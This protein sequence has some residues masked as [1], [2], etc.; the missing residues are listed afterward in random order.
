MTENVDNKST[1]QKLSVS[2]DETVRLLPDYSSMQDDEFFAILNNSLA[3]SNIDKLRRVVK[4]KIIE[5]NNEKDYIMVDSGLK[6]EGII[7]TKEFFRSQDKTQI[8]EGNEIETYISSLDHCGKVVVSREKAIREES[9][10]KIV[11]AHKSGE[12]VE[13]LV[14]AKTRSG[15]VVDID[16]VICFLPGSQ[17]DS[18]VFFEGNSILGTRQKVM[19]IHL[20]TKLRNVVVSRK[21]V[22]DLSRKEFRNAFLDKVQEGDIVEGVVKNITPYGAFVNLGDID[23]LLHVTDISWE[24][25]GHPAEVLK[26]GQKL[27]VKILKFSRAE[28][29]ISLGIKQL[30]DNPWNNFG[31]KYQIGNKVKGKIVN[32]TNY[33]IFIGLEEKIDG[34]VH[35]SELSWKNDAAKKL[36]EEYKLGQEVEAVILDINIDKHRISLGIKQLTDS[37]WVSFISSYK[38]GDVIVG[39]ITN[40]IDFGIFV[41]LNEQI[42][43]LVN[44]N[45]ICYG[46]DGYVPSKYKIGDEIKAM[47]IEGNIETQRVRLGIKQFFDDKIENNKAS[48]VQGKPVDCNVCEIRHDGLIVSVLDGAIFSFIKKSEAGDMFNNAQIGDKTKA[49]IVSYN[50]LNKKVTLSIKDYESNAV[51][52]SQSQQSS[53]IGDIIDNLDSGKK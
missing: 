46:I 30:Q 18:E 17:V 37:P 7:S 43:G 13:A 11:E 10:N 51:Y 2:K 8:F 24:K 41:S 19:I 52:G 53:T 16:A 45:D 25:I 22:K 50:D 36:K 44:V 3:E 12:P 40:I 33:G 38:S 15:F 1:E 21:A 48:L 5:V 42:D 23:G 29:K 28:E 4:S 26:I 35:M 34:L 6:S 39:K 27:K 47:Y 20:D 49:T 14:F 31:T 9:W 32:I